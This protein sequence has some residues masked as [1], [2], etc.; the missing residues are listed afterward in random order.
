MRLPLWIGET[1]EA[2]WRVGGDPGPFPRDLR[3]PIAWGLPVA[4]LQLPRLRLRSIDDWLR[5]RGVSCSLD[6]GD[7]ALRA[8]L[9]ARGGQGF[10]FLEG[11]DPEDEQRLS[12]AHELA[13]YLRD[14]WQP[15]QRVREQLGPAALE[16]IDGARA[17]RPAEEVHALLARTPLG[18]QVHLLDRTADGDYLT[19]ATAR[20][21][22]AADLLAYELLAP[23]DLLRQAVADLPTA[24]HPEHAE[25]LLRS[26]YGLPPRPAR[27]Y[28]AL[29]FAPP[30]AANPLLRHLLNGR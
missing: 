6:G 1:A 30:E 21:E 9:V 12:L 3:A 26:R 18:Y 23:E 13:H 17:A 25:E 19:P 14:Y 22:R 24:K 7:R 10:I 4:I 8:C 29:L 20:T 16:V 28:A 5:S 2:F 15:R 27:A 11:S